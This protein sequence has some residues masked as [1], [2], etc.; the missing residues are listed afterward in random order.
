MAIVP[1]DN[2]NVH[3][4]YDNETKLLLV[5]Y[6]GILSPQVTNEFY[7][8][9]FGI[10]KENPT[11]IMEARGSI[12]DFRDVKDFVNSNLSTVRK[13]SQTVNQNVEARN[14]PV[15]LLV[16][17]TL[18]ERMVAVTL[19]LTPQNDRKKIVFS[20]DEAKEYITA[21]HKKQESVGEENP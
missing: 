3:A 17:T 19:K 4:I 2:E 9:V 20:M 11:L 10:M 1:L 6:K 7:T 8:W 5:T 15:A 12:F 21:W 18:Q 16:K 13:Q 14:H